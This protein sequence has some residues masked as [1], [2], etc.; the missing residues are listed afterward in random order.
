MKHELTEL[1]RF[2]YAW[3]ANIFSSILE[4]EDIE[5]FVTQMNALEPAMGFVVYVNQHDLAS[6]QALLKAFDESTPEPI[7]E[8]E[9]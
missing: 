2:Q 5:N 6:A 3:Q 4:Q 9:L 1:V 7:D 8:P